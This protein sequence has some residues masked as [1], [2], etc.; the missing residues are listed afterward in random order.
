MF[1]ELN[2]WTQ[3]SAVSERNIKYTP[4]ASNNKIFSM[5]SGVIREYEGQI[6]EYPEKGLTKGNK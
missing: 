1:T 5:E 6:T 2:K 4:I 3:Y